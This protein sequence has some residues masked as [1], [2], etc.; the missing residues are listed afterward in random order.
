VTTPTHLQCPYCPAQ[1]YPTGLERWL[2]TIGAVA[3]FSC[4]AKHTFYTRL[5]TNVRTSAS[6]LPYHIADAA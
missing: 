4:P 3:Q 1:S 2:G 5:E 6:A